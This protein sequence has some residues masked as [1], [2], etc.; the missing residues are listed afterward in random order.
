MR[1]K[2]LMEAARKFR[3]SDIH[4]VAGAPPAFRVDGEIMLAERAILGPQDIEAIIGDVTTQEQREFMER[5]REICFSMI[6][7]DQTRARVSIYYS[8][9]HAELAVRVCPD[10]IPTL[11]ELNLP[12]FIETIP[13]MATGLVI[14]T[15]PTGMGKTTTMNYIIDRINSERRC[16]IITIEDPVEFTHHHKRSIVVQ[17]EVRSD[18]LSFSRALIH[19]LR[20]DP[21]VIAIGEMRDLETMQTALTAAETGHLV[22][23]TLHTPDTSQTVDRIVGV[24]PA[25]QQDQVRLQFANTLQAA[26]AQKLLPRANG[27]GRALAC[28]ILVATM[29]V[30]GI[31]REGGTQKLYSILQTGINQSMQTMD[32]A[33]LDLYL[34]GEITYDVALSNATHQN[35]IE[36]RSGLNAPAK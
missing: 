26:I 2:T 36:S 12:A 14:V 28:E 4:V 27:P 15:G 23:A 21:D 17:Q 10:S 11:Q 30:R 6:L 35:F 31:I 1:F 29:A 34:R 25:Y 20:Q 24:F 5:E 22:L 9:G 33:L 19:A 32:A 18:T 8:A 13:W 7:E 3:A 16:K